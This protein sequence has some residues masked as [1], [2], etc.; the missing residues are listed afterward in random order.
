MVR[1]ILLSLIALLG[2]GILLSLAQSKQ[3]SGTVTGPD[4]KPVAGAT[5]MVDGSH[6]GT[7]SNGDGSF[8]ITAPGN[9]SLVVSFIG[10]E[11]QKVAIGGKT[12]INISLKEDAQA[13]DDVIVV[14]FG[15][16]KKDAFTGA[17]KVIKSDDLI[18][19]QSSNVGDA[20]VGKIAGV[21]F[22]SASGR[23]GSGQ[24]IYVRGYGSM[25]AKND[26]LWVVDGVPY[27]GDINN[28]NAA[29]IESISVLKDAASNAL[30]GSRG[31]N[32]VIMVTTKRAKAGEATV[33][34]TPVRCRPTTSWRMRA[35]T[36]RCTTSRCTT[37]TRST[38]STLP[39]PPTSPPT[40]C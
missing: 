28:I 8:T 24:K 40:S 32:G 11:T 36:T 37:I 5:V 15:T 10:Y 14:A 23:P 29:D 19:T 26:P 35:N 34:S 39:W 4:G 16:A 18:K 27:E 13:I 31:A 3:I 9:G 20:L 38:R 6:V 21:Q 17:A 30:Y 25:N 12:R 33:T 2:G 7:T 22:S 1:K